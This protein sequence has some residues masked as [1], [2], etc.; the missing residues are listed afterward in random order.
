MA[1]IKPNTFPVVS[2][3][4]G[5]EEIYT[6]TANVNGKFTIDELKTF[7][8]DGFSGTTGTT[9]G[10][11]LDNMLFV[12]E[13]GDDG[14]AEVGNLNKTWATI[15]GAFSSAVAGDTIHIFAGNYP[16]G[17]SG[18]DRLVKDGVILHCT[19]G[20][21]ITQAI[22]ST[23]DLFYDGG[24]AQIM[25]ITGNGKFVLL[26]PT[27]APDFTLALTNVASE[28]YFEG[29]ELQTEIRWRI[30]DME[31]IRLKF[32][33]II[34]NNSGLLSIRL[35]T[36]FDSKTIVVEADTYTENVSSGYAGFEVRDAR[37]NC[38]IRFDIGVIKIQQA[39]NLGGF[40]YLQTI[41]DSSNITVNVNFIEKLTLLSRDYFISEFGVH[42]SRN[43]N[44]QIK[45]AIGMFNSSTNLA[46]TKTSRSKIRFVHELIS[47]GLLI[48]PFTTSVKSE[49]ADVYI[50]TFIPAGGSV[51]PLSIFASDYVLGGTIVWQFG[52]VYTLAGTG[53]SGGRLCK[54]KN[55][56]IDTN[57]AASIGRVGGA[58]VVP[59]KYV[60][61]FTTNVDISAFTVSET[62]AA[63]KVL[64]VGL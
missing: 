8:L 12:S 19:S 42:A 32:R 52:G 59:A 51:N 9:T 55:L 39:F 40:I 25:K 50:D 18:T 47:S 49:H 20:V 23:T 21:V 28:L 3:I 17:T 14:S 29:D 41:D 26:R 4:T 36:G 15:A 10:G 53:F 34:S 38:N 62:G 22:G 31:S 24:A 57:A 13:N 27:A 5:L 60:G 61:N 16:V 63:N 56:F 45:G 44:A 35:A 58:A 48:N 2:P 6:Q 1:G 37:T 43:Y 46:G 7:V 33:N 54:I 11:T 30:T 64:D